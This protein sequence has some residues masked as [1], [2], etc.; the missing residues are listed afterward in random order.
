MNSNY[1]DIIDIILTFTSD[2]E[3]SGDI[4]VSGSI[5]P[6]LVTNKESLEYHSDFYILVKNKK[7]N[8]VRDKIKKLTKEYEF[9]FI[10]DSK[11]YSKEDYGFKVKYQG[12]TVG[13]FPYSLIDIS[14]W[15]DDIDTESFKKHKLEIDVKDKIVVLVDDVL[16]SGRTVRAAMDGIMDSGR[17]KAIHLA[18]LIDRGH[19]E[20]PIR[21]DHVGK[22]VPTSTDENVLV[23]LYEVDQEEGVYIE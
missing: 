3:L 21:A 10:S 19:R 18:V 4:A 23:K 6:Y 9:D 11:K 1:N 15:R 22:N 14:F 7:I 17:P 16:S 5:V 20:L 13:F 8:L 12:T 2:E